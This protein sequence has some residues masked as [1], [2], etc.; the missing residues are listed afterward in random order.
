MPEILVP[1][2][3]DRQPEKRNVQWKPPSSLPEPPTDDPDWVFRWVATDVLG[4]P[5]PSNVA[6]RLQEGWEPVDV[7]EY[8]HLVKGIRAAQAADGT[9]RMGGL[10]LCKM[11]RALNQSRI[12]YHEQRTEAQL[13][14]AR[15]MVERDAKPDPT[16]PMTNETKIGRGRN[17]GGFGNGR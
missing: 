2:R 5:I 7:K 3:P 4:A 17:I 15:G 14:D 11:S 12:E 10:M 9:I 8:P 1:Q 6:S 13:G 16:M